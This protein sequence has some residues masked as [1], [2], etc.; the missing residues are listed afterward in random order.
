METKGK[1]KKS[2]RRPAAYSRVTEVSSCSC[3]RSHIPKPVLSCFSLLAAALPPGCCVHNPQWW[4]ALL[5]ISHSFHF[6]PCLFCPL[7]LCIS[8]WD[9][10]TQC[11]FENPLTAVGTAAVACPVAGGNHQHSGTGSHTTRHSG[12]SLFNKRSEAAWLRVRKLCF[13]S[14]TIHYEWEVFAGGKKTGISPER[15]SQFACVPECK[16]SAVPLD[17]WLEAV[18]EQVYK[19]NKIHDFFTELMIEV[20]KQWTS[21]I[22]FSFLLRVAHAQ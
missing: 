21:L 4:F 13:V 1:K 11:I 3:S 17:S 14:M 7:L 10:P 19:K 9:K 22:P 20:A 15:C 5:I 16:C 8:S 12:T 2:S 18:L 6:W